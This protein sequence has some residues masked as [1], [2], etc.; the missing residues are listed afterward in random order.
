MNI[1]QINFFTK[2][3]FFFR[4]NHF[5]YVYFMYIDSI[6][7]E[8]IDINFLFDFEV[9]MRKFIYEMWRRMIVLKIQTLNLI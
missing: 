9:F 4:I 3:I 8:N 2:I 5:E 7:F 6:L 1:D